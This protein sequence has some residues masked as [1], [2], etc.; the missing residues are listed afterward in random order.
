MPIMFGI[1]IIEHAGMGFVIIILII[2]I[3]N[4]VIVGRIIP[5]IIGIDN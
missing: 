4:M 1:V 2:A 3:A 5:I